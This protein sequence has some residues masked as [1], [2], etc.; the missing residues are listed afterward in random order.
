MESNK[1]NYILKEAEAILAD[2]SLKFEQQTQKNNFRKV[3]KIKNLEK[4]YKSLKL[5]TKI[6]S[7]LLI[8]SIIFNII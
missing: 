6:L 1:K 5:I 3:K 4:K 8:I 7:A 2:C